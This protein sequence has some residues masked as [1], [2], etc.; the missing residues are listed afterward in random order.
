MIMSMQYLN[1]THRYRFTRD[2]NYLGKQTNSVMEVGGSYF[3]ISGIRIFLYIERLVRCVFL[4]PT[5]ILLFRKSSYTFAILRT[6]HFY[7]RSL[8]TFQH[9][10]SF[11]YKL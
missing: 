11:V 8:H 1:T 5:Y 6:R 2:I 7:I 9:K 4:G 3:I 10:Q